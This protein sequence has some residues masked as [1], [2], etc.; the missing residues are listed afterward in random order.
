MSAPGE[1]WKV[2][3]RL[4]LTGRV[5]DVSIL[6]CFMFCPDSRLLR[7]LADIRFSVGLG[8]RGRA[9]VGGGPGGASAR[10][11]LTEDT[12]LAGLPEKRALSKSSGTVDNDDPAVLRSD[13]CELCHVLLE[14][15][16]ES[17][18]RGRADFESRSNL[19]P[20]P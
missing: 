16:L 14:Y 7:T 13:T 9:L 1:W 12:I 2:D 15:P 10:T 18:C 11:V 20:C 5:V 6:S 8:G 17:D 4:R 19:K 3:A